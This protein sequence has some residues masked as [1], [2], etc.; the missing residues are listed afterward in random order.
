MQL[1]SKKIMGTTVLITKAFLL[2]LNTIPLRFY[3]GV[4]FLKT[5][6]TGNKRKDLLTDREIFALTS[7]GKDIYIK[8]LGRIQKG[9]IKRPWGEDNHPSFGIWQAPDGMWMWKDLAADKSGNAIQFVQNLFQLSYSDAV[10]KVMNDFGIDSFDVQASIVHDVKP[11]DKPSLPVPITARVMRFGPRHHAFWNAV[12]VS[13]DWCKKFD[14]YAVKELAINRRR[15]RM[16]DNEIVFVYLARDTNQVKVYFPDREGGDRFRTNV[17]FHYLWQAH[18]TSPCDRLVVHKSMKDLITF[19]QLHP[20]NVATQNESVSV[21]ND[22]TVSTINSL[23]SDVWLFYGSDADGVRKC[24]EVT[25]KHGWR[26][27]NTPSKMLPEVNDVYSFVK[28]HGLKKL[29]EFCK[30][31]NLI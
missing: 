5:M 13:E 29:E 30:T 3:A 18:K 12:G 8:Y 11:L 22:E 14:C 9:A 24:K 2:I 26:Y 25:D 4:S 10:K 1:S 31:K 7:G 17:P 20:H 6:I 21:F 27:I 19:A 16:G 28:K 15:V 23:S